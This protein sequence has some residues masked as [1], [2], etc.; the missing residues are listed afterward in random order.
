MSFISV[1]YI[2]SFDSKPYLSLN[3]KLT[4]TKITIIWTIV[5]EKTEDKDSTHNQFSS[6][7]SPTSYHVLSIRLSKTKM[8]TFHDALLV[9]MRCLER[10]QKFCIFSTNLKFHNQNK[11]VCNQQISYVSETAKWHWYYVYLTVSYYNSVLYE[12]TYYFCI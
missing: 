4:C 1:W 5:K 3:V 7:F 11:L 2:K 12:L 6:I 9:E 10:T 8:M